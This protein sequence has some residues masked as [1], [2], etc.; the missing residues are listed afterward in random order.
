M[1]NKFLLFF[2]CLALTLSVG[3]LGSFFTVSEI[4]GWYVGINKPSFNP[5]S[6]I[7]GPVWTTLYIMIAVSLYLILAK[8]YENK[9]KALGYFFV[10]LGLNFAWSLVFFGLHS[11]LGA[12]LIILLL[13]LFVALTILEFQKISRPAAWLLV[14]YLLWISFATVL[15]FSIWMLN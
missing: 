4:P 14:P 6:W 13:D 9:K 5:P 3:F 15:N 11:P 12:L 10:Q 1:K 7:F 8:K 2:L